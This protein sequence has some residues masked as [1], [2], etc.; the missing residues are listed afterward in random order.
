MSLAADLKDVFDSMQS[1]EDDGDEFGR[2]KAFAEGVT[3]AVQ[4]SFEM[5]VCVSVYSEAASVSTVP[6]TFKIDASESRK[7]C[8]DIILNHC[9]QMRE[10]AVV[11]VDPLADDKLMM[12]VVDGISAMVTGAELTEDIAGTTDWDDTVTGSATGNFNDAVGK[13]A[14]LVALKL[15]PVSMP[16]VPGLGDSLLANG[17]AGAIAGEV[18]YFSSCMTQMQG[19][20][21]Y[22]FLLGT[23]LMT[24]NM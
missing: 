9:K 7:D 5:G 23:G 16:P 12:A 8:Y 3:S 20:G 13:P 19:D 6:G 1:L 4:T 17:L 22:S 21:A 24:G 10:D 18:G 2:D 15:I 11:A 14:L